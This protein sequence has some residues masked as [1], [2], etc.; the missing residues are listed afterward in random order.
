M[1]LH[2]SHGAH[3]APLALDVVLVVLFFVLFKQCGFVVVVVVVAVDACLI[4]ES[5]HSVASDGRQLVDVVVLT[6]DWIP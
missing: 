6:R 1:S 2:T 4:L 5:V 3:G